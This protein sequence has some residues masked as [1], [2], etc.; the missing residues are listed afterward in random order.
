VR[1]YWSPTLPEWF[2]FLRRLR[3]RQDVNFWRPGS[4][5][6]RALEPGGPFLFKIRGRDF[7]GGFGFFQRFEELSLWEAWESF[8]I[9]NGAPDLGTFNRQIA[10]ALRVPAVSPKDHRIG[11]IMLTGAVFFEESDL[12]QRARDWAVQGAQGGATFSL[13]EGEGERVWEE[14]QVR[15]AAYG[16]EAPVAEGII[17]EGIIPSAYLRESRPGQRIFK[18]SLI[19]AY[20]GACAI[21]NEHSLPV[22]DAAHILPYSEQGPD[23]VA[24]GLLIRTDIHRL[25][26]EGYV[27]ITPKYRFEVGNSLRDRF[28]NGREYY[29]IRDELHGR[30]I[31][32]PRDR[33][34]WPDPMNLEWHSRERFLG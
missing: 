2:T 32:R 18:A 8:N 26:D 17:A 16:S 27:T 20:E 28:G 33:R 19:A 31:R 30:E 10:K 12:V 4:R 11:C 13:S 21:T 29:E 1:G 22:L 14:C 24:N 15:R 9:L 6:F 5:G 23:R 25:F 7:V 34:D 3:T